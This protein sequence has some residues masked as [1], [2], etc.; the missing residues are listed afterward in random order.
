MVEKNSEVW[1]SSLLSATH[2]LCDLEQVISPPW[3]SV[4]M[5]LKWGDC[6]CLKIPQGIIE[7][8]RDNVWVRIVKREKAKQ[9]KAVLITSATQ[10]FYMFCL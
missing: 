3:A 1:D 9:M 5:S 10:K 4:S 6:G 7:D 8:A 2:H